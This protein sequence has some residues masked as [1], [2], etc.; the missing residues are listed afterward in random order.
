MTTRKFKPGL[1]KNL[2]AALGLRCRNVEVISG[3]QYG[4]WIKGQ[5]N[6]IVVWV[7]RPTDYQNH[8]CAIIWPLVA[9]EEFIH[10][11]QVDGA[12]NNNSQRTA[13]EFPCVPPI[14]LELKG[15]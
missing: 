10:S 15:R 2:H 3:L 7:T 12:K 9:R 14:Y 5:D 6:V 8:A 4:S 1:E 13:T 11:G